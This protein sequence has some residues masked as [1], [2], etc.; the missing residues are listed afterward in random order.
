VPF[1]WV[2]RECWAPW[3]TAT[4]LLLA[5]FFVLDAAAGARAPRRRPPGDA[6]SSGWR[7]EGLPNLLFLALVVGAV[8]IQRPPFL[9]EGLMLAAAAGSYFT[10]RKSVYAANEFNFHPLAEVAVLFA[11]IFATMMPALDWLDHGAARWLGAS[12]GPAVFY[13]GTGCLSA[14]L[15][16]APT[17]LGFLNALFGVAG[18]REIAPLLDHRA[19]QLAAI[20]V[21]A[22]FFGA[23]TYLG[24]GPNFMVKAIA[25]Q[26]GVPMPSFVEFILKFSLPFLAPVLLVVWLLFFRD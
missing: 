12:P 10:T 11:G 8:F 13:W 1:W 4:G 25:D 5:I 16:N 18:T 24:N 2:A 23:A 22:V 21:G 7:W 15:D 20:S 6:P 14:V 9:R 3:A 26:R 17:Y 19:A